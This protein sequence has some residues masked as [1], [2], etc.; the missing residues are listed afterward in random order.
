M[1]EKKLIKSD[2][3]VPIYARISID[4]IPVDLSTKES[5]L[6]AHWNFEA[7]RIKPRIKNAKSINNVLDEVYAKIKNAF[8]ELKSEGKVITA[9][10]VK[11]RYLG[12]DKAALTFKS[13]SLKDG[14]FYSHPGSGITA[15]FL[16]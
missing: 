12:K 2:G 11:Q 6:E 15:H 16:D 13:L 7:K 8:N 1:V 3:M 5:T 4:S 10:A 14:F 9:Q